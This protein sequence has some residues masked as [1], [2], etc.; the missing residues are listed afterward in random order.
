[1]QVWAEALRNPRLAAEFTTMLTG[2]HEEISGMVRRHQAAGTLP[3]GV[4]SDALASVL[5]GTVPGYL[6]QMA[7]LGDAAPTG[8]ADAVRALWPSAVDDTVGP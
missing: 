8:V 6:V 5:L 4:P 7:L 3:D 2:V 1:V